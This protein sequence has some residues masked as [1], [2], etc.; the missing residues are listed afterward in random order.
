MDNLSIESVLEFL[1]DVMSFFRGFNVRGMFLFVNKCI[2][3]ME[4]NVEEVV[5]IEG[6]FFFFKLVMI[7]F[8]LSE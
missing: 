6:F 3:F 2:G 4:E 8:V 5:K 1:V 7:R